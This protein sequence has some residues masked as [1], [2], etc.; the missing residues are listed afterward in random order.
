MRPHRPWVLTQS[1]AVI[2][3]WL[4]L[5]T[6]CHATI[7]HTIREGESIALVAKHYYGDPAKAPLLMVYNGI[8]DPRNIKP[9]WRIVIPEVT[10]HTVKKGD[11]LA[12]IAKRYLRDAKKSRGLAA[13]NE[14][15]DPRALVP[16]MAIVVPVE[17]PYTVRKGDTLATIAQTYYGNI[18]ALNLIALYNDITDPAGLKAGARLTLPIRDLRVVEHKSPTPTPEPTE[19]PSTRIS[20]ETLLEKGC[21]DYF[22][23]DYRGAVKNLEDA[24]TLG[25]SG[26]EATSKAHRFLAYCYVALDERER[27][28]DAFQQALRT[29]PNLT[30]DPVYVSPKIIDVFEEVKGAGMDPGPGP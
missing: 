28:M 25:L 29:D 1:A 23:G 4:V 5:W 24:L 8:D 10:V 27:A 30:L 2:V 16:G 19:T 21:N 6:P 11:T 14:I 18:D 13:V 12:L 22:M 3:L 17:V 26:T 15:K 9:G 20:G 7:Q